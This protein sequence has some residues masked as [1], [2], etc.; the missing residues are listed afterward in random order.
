MRRQCARFGCSAVATATFTFD[1]ETCTV[2]LDTPLDGGARAGELCGRHARSLTPPR[3]WRLEDRRAGATARA[4]A[5]T[6]PRGRP[7]RR[8]S[9]PQLAA[10]PPGGELE[11]ELARSARRA[12]P[13]PGAGFSELRYRLTRYSVGAATSAPRP[14]AGRQDRARDGRDRH[15][16]GRCERACA[17]GGESPV[18]SSG[19]KWSLR[20]GSQYRR[21][22]ARAGCGAPAVATLRFQSTERQ[23][24]LVELDENAA[25]T[26]GD[27]CHRH[28]ARSCS[29]A[30]GSC[31]TSATPGRRAPVAPTARRH[32]KRRTATERRDG[33]RR[34]RRAATDDRR[35]AGPNRPDAG[36]GRRSRRR[37]G[38]ER[39]ADGHGDA[40]VPAQFGAN[41]DDDESTTR[42]SSAILDA[43]TPLLQ[44]A[45]RNAQP[46][47]PSR[48]SLDAASSRSTS[49]A[50]RRRRY[51]I[52]RSSTS[53]PSGSRT[54]TPA[55]MFESASTSPP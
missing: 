23:A 12:E 29:R 33:A 34:E 4:G 30:A 19:P 24:W 46:A 52:G 53:W 50:S 2:W 18:M 48:D 5:S 32:A 41:D 38:T 17:C 10:G 20:N 15:R 44:R 22:C 14:S 16:D 51:A 49:A 3:G 35:D 6:R 8:P 40:P 54:N 25:R 43:R 28:A 7:E 55:P 37:R 21:L 9:T 39:R 11:D 27:L 47:D 42:R 31:T 26:Q 13:A 1:S 36:H 45:F